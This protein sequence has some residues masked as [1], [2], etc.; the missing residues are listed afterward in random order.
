M[1]TV[2]GP[3]GVVNNYIP[4]QNNYNY[5]TTNN[6]AQTNN[7][8][9]NNYYP[10][11]QQQQQPVINNYY[12]VQQ[13]SQPQ[14]IVNNYYQAPQVQQPVYQQPQMMPTQTYPQMQAYPM[15]PQSVPIIIAP[16]VVQ[17]PAQENTNNNNNSKMM[18]MFKMMIQ[19]VTGDKLPDKKITVDDIMEYLE[20]GSWGDPHFTANGEQAFDFMGQKGE[21]YK[22]LDNKDVSLTA[23]FGDFKKGDA[24]ETVVTD[25]NLK[26]KDT[27]LNIVSHAGG[28]FEIYQNGKKVAD[29]TN[30]KDENVQKILKENKID[31]TYENDTLT[32]KHGNRVISQKLID[33]RG[34]GSIDN[35]KDT[36][37]ES[38]TGLLTQTAGALDDNFDGKT[39]MKTDVNKDGKIDDNDVLTYNVGNQ[40]M[41]HSEMLAKADPITD[42]VKAALEKDF[43]TGKSQGSLA[44][45][46]NASHGYTAAQWN[47]YVGAKQFAVTDKY[48]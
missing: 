35:V 10:P 7:Y 33:E 45:G 48:L 37:A 24:N 32:A 5:N 13:Q 8:Y 28:K 12:P 4:P 42:K 40:A 17:Q 39:T 36:L 6:Y 25:Q 29:Q 11:Q 19:L 47:E 14:T 1:V 26:F 43:A 15:Q 44:K 22:M 20:T 18:D 38:D 3:N 9:T 27:N 23:K 41:V 30:L 46:F 21:T 16:P 31:L 2:Y 34:D